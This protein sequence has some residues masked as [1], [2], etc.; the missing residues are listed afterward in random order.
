MPHSSPLLFQ[1]SQKNA[2]T[3]GAASSGRSTK[4]PSNVAARLTAS[5]I[6]RACNSNVDSS[7]DKANVGQKKNGQCGCVYGLD[8]VANKKNWGD[9]KCKDVLES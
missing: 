1:V 2:S 6:A 5:N 7:T 4:A 8:T 3:S 9:N